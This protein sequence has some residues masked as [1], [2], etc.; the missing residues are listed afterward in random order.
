M[1]FEAEKENQAAEVLQVGTEPVEKTENAEIRVAK[2]TEVVPDPQ[3][4]LENAVLR[5]VLDAT[6]RT[7]TVEK[8]DVQ[9]ARVKKAREVPP[10]VL[11][12]MESEDHL[13]APEN[14]GLLAVLEETEKT[15]SVETTDVQVALENA[16]LEDFLV[17]PAKMDAMEKMVAQV[18]PVSVVLQVARAKE[19]QSVRAD[20][21]DLK[22][23]REETVAQEA[24]EK[25]VS[26]DVQVREVP[27]DVLVLWV[28][29]DLQENVEITETTESAD[30][31]GKTVVRVHRARKDVTDVKV[32]AASA[33]PRAVEVR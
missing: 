4:A 1:D 14:A 16:G 19:G 12:A 30:D 27:V 33:V 2:G 13:V 24:V 32:L 22:V 15:E 3:V 18:A 28:L 9:D 5:D 10:A 20:V 8:T 23:D 11:D 7:E 26:E 31:P 6:G 29:E 25:K 17:V 21:Q